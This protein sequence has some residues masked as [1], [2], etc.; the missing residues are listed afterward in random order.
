MLGNAVTNQAPK[1]PKLNLD[2]PLKH[3]VHA[4]VQVVGDV[5]VDTTQTSLCLDN[6]P[7]GLAM[8]RC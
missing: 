3:P 7:K 1:P 5:D 2:K 8:L 6:R 4:D